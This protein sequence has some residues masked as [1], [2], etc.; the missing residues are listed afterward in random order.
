MIQKKT[1]SSITKDFVQLM[2]LWILIIVILG[3]MLC[4]IIGGLM[5]PLT[6]PTTLIL[7]AGFTAFVIWS[8][9]HQRKWTGRMLAE[10]EG[11]SICTFARSLPARNHDTKIVR[12][13][14]EQLHKVLSIPLRPQDEL[15]E[16][17]EMDPE[18]LEDLVVEMAKSSGKSMDEYEANPLA[19][20]VITVADLIIFLEMQPSAK[21]AA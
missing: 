9:T 12:V 4:S 13:V 19:G 7:L 20:H 10:R 5:D 14:Y 2:A 6:R 18:D 8:V 16:T 21:S 3:I 1:L 17:L 11:E 15:E